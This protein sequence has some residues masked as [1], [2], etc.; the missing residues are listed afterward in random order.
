MTI[1]SR[2]KAD[3]ARTRKMISNTEKAYKL[4]RP[5]EN[6][7]LEILLAAEIFKKNQTLNQYLNLLHDPELKLMDINGEIK[8]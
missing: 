7:S 1:R 3:I 8:K 2:L 4:I 5:L 6:E